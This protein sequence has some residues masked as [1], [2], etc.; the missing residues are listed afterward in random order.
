[1]PSISETIAT[2]LALAVSSGGVGLAWHYVTGR[3]DRH[4]AAQRAEIVA[5]RAELAATAARLADS[6]VVVAG[7]GA[8]LDAERESRKQDN[9]RT[10]MAIAQRSTPAQAATGAEDWESM[11]TQVRRALT[12]IAAA[13]SPSEDPFPDLEG[14]DPKKKSDPPVVPPRARMP[15][16]H[17]R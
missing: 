7:L 1:M 17:D 10:A 8:K 6:Q 13:V 4:D 11:P 12:M 14:W 16:R 9:E 2:G 5:L 15:S 3:I